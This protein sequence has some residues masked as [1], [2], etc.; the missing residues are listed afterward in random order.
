MNL[1]EITIGRSKDC[2]IYLDSRCKYASNMHGT[3]YFDG[4]QMMYKDTSTNGTLINNISVRHRAV[5]I[6][7]GDII[8]LAGKYPLN[9][10]QISSF[11][12]YSQHTS[13]NPVGVIADLNL[14]KSEQSC[15]SDSLELSK[16]SWGAFVLSWIWGF[17]NGCWWM[18]LVKMGVFLLSVLLY[19]VPFLAFFFTIVD[20]GISVLF[21]IKGTEWAWHNR[22]W[23]S[24]TD[25]NQTQNVW[26][27]VGLS[28]FLL[29]IIIMIISV[30][31]FFAAISSLFSM[32]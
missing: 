7:H 24:I 20:I 15:S 5:P 8:M 18:F 29:G 12:P 9:W 11:F 25:F 4:N 13:S 21:G 1:R 22:K 23:N 27:K 2:D 16:W 26:N 31:F 30:L 32:F 6:K 28:I 3:I 19:W 17:F 10:C 14:T